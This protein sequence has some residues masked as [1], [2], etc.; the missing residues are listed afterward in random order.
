LRARGRVV[1]A[2]VGLYFAALR[3]AEMV[4]VTY[5]TGE[6]ELYDLVANPYQVENQVSGASPE[7]L[8][9]LRTIA[10]AM[11]SCE[12]ARCRGIDQQSLLA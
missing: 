9:Q 1:D 5:G 7:W 11:L 8:A 3:T 4:Y 10:E 2:L 12:G 6:Q